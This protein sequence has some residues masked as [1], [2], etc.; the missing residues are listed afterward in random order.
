MV[1][2]FIIN[3]QIYL[4]G[5]RAKHVHCSHYT[6]K[7]V[8]QFMA[9]KNESYYT[10][11]MLAICSAPLQ[12]RLHPVKSTVRML[13]EYFTLWQMTEKDEKGSYKDSKIIQDNAD[14]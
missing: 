4:H 3:G 8:C 13:A 11:I 14:K 6:L 10:L 2:K 12:V 1:C 9:C 7:I 5:D